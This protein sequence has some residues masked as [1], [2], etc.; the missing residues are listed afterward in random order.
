MKCRLPRTDFGNSFSYAL[1]KWQPTPVLLPGKSQRWRSLV[2][3]IY[4]VAK[5]R[6]WLSDFTHLSILHIEIWWLVLMYLI[7]HMHVAVINIEQY[8]SIWLMWSSIPLSVIIPYGTQWHQVHIQWSTVSNFYRKPQ[9]Y[10]KMKESLHWRG[11]KY[12]VE[13]GDK[14]FS[15]YAVIHTAYE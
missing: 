15:D 2:G 12:C 10:L 14:S 8:V 5:S 13:K 11:R 9:G 4:G 1:R 6:T 7:W 3:Y